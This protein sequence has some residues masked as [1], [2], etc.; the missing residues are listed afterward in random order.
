MKKVG[1]EYPC[2]PCDFPKECSCGTI[3]TE[4]N[5]V[6]DRCRND[7]EICDYCSTLKCP[8]CGEHTCCGGCI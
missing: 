8:D 4:I 3:L 6:S 7:C 2:G 1:S 5:V